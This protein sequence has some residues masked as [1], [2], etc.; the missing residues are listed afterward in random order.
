MRIM[1]DGEAILHPDPDEILALT[2]EAVLP[3]MANLWTVESD[4]GHPD[5]DTLLGAGQLARRRRTDGVEECLTDWLRKRSDYPAWDVVGL[6]LMGFWCGR[7]SV[8]PELVVRLVD[9]LRDSDLPESARDSVINA[10]GCAHRLVDQP[11]L[12]RRIEDVFRPL[13]ARR[14]EHRLQPGVEATLSHILEG[15]NS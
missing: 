5:L 13:W 10:L 7:Q 8:D 12:A 2:A 15:K 4:S 14:Q 9:S 11:S 1:D 6:F 3:Y